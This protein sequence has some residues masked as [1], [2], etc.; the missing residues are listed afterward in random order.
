MSVRWGFKS[1]ALFDEAK[2][3]HT[4]YPIDIICVQARSREAV[5]QQQK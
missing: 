5:I 4:S 3:V 1:Q 2:A